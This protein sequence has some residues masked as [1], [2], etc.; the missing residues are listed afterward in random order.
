M[1]SP[2]YAAII[3]EALAGVHD[4]V[5]VC[6]NADKVRGR[7]TRLEPTPVKRVALERALPVST[8]E[9]LRDEGVQAKLRALEPDAICVAAYGKILPPEMLQVPRFGC[10]NVHAS[11]LPRWRGAA[12]VQRAIL[13]GDEVQGVSIMRMEAGLDTGDYALQA[14]CDARGKSAAEMTRELAR[15]GADALLEVLAQVEAGTVIWQHQDES[16]A[17][18]AAKIAKHELNLFPEDT[19][20]RASAKVLASDDAHP[21]KCIIA[22]KSVAIISAY[23]E[24]FE[25]AAG[26]VRLMQGKLALGFADGVLAVDEVKPDG[27]A[28]MDGKAFAAGLQGIK[29]GLRWTSAGEADQ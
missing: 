16:L 13:S 20:A 7:G 17:T 8:P 14:S 5:D 28:S 29:T 18:Y 11:L 2:E 27:K 12:P 21:A 25:L 24:G 9:T 26:E 19:A 4:V 10:L 22:H 6:T 15:I 3:L 23:V 1:G